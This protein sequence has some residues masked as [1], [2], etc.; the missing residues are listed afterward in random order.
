MTPAR[1]WR[2]CFTL[3]AAIVLVSLS[4]LKWT[5]I[6]MKN[7]RQLQKSINC[8]SFSILFFFHLYSKFTDLTWALYKIINALLGKQYKQNEKSAKGI[9]MS[10][11]DPLGKWRQNDIMFALSYQIMVFRI[12]VCTWFYPGYRGGRTITAMMIMPKTNRSTNEGVNQQRKWADHQA[13]N[14][15]VY[16]ETKQRNN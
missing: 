7:I 3:L 5:N 1:V 8:S 15:K 6:Q 4:L 16:D 2:H 14:N 10:F 11:P 9:R 13:E 12:F